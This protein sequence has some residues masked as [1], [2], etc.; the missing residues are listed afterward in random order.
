MSSRKVQLIYRFILFLLLLIGLASNLITSLFNGF[1]TYAYYTFQSNIICFIIIVFQLSDTISSLRRHQYYEDSE[2]FVRIQ[3][4][5]C[6]WITI[7]CLVYNI[8]LG[9]PLTPL[10]WTK[11]L[12]NPLLHLIVPILFVL[13]FLLFSARREISK[14]LPLSAVV[15]PYLYITFIIIRVRIIDFIYNP[16]PSYVVKYP[17]FFLD[18]SK[19]GYIGVIKWT[20][21]LTV[22]FLV[23]S[24]AL[25]FIYDHTK[26]Y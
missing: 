18:V 24:Y 22:L 13:D 19:I 11:N 2:K 20:G 25:K 6:I 23:F 12:H 5:A 26:Q 15:F 1:Q 21:I 14:W 7:T 3:F 9:N 16:I 4:L 17:Y 8:L 10:Y